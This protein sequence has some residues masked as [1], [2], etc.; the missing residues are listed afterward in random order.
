MIFKSSKKVGTFSRKAARLIRFMACSS[1]LSLILGSFSYNS[2][3][4][5]SDGWYKIG[6]HEYYIR[7]GERVTGLQEI[8][9]LMYEFSDKGVLMSTNTLDVSRYQGDIDWYAVKNAGFDRAIIQVGY[10]GYWYGNIRDDYKFEENINQAKDAGVNVGYYFVTF[11]VNED[12]AREEAD[13]LA[14]AA[15]RYGA[16]LPLAMDMEGISYDDTRTDDLGP[17]ERGY[18]I[19][20][21]AERVRERGYEPMI[22]A[23]KYWMTSVINMD[24]VPDYCKVWVAQ[25]YS[26][27]TYDSRY[28]YWQ[29]SSEYSCPG[30]NDNSVDV[31]LEYRPYDDGPD[32]GDVDGDS[33]LTVA[34]LVATKK[35]VM[36]EELDDFNKDAADLNKDGVVDIDDVITMNRLLAGF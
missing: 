10:R 26:E 16:Q 6:D 15:D 5:A 12:E 2:A 35:Y 33:Y 7:D 17:D 30:I 34:D 24:L 36:G 18:I 23:S 3:F 29:Y 32:L 1:A 27:C 14:D 20:A 13:Y 9:G 4:A 31:S 22:Y 11:A 25:Y 8:G 19:A 28:D 21:F